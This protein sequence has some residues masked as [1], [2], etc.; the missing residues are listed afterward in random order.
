MGNPLF[1]SATEEEEEEEEG[2]GRGDYP[3]FN[4]TWAAKR[5][6]LTMGSTP[7]LEEKFT[8]ATSTATGRFAR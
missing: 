8:V 4:W 2:E 7:P 3:D 5:E 1:F 6:F